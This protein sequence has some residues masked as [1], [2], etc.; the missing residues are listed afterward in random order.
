MAS[1]G[2][3]STS[4][5]CLLPPGQLPLPQH[6]ILHHLRGDLEAKHRQL[7]HQYSAKA[8]Y[9]YE[10]RIDRL[11]RLPRMSL[12]QAEDFCN[13]T[14]PFYIYTATEF[15]PTPLLLTALHNWLY[16]KWFQPYRSEIEWGQFV[17]KVV[18]LR[19]VPLRTPPD[20][21]VD[22]VIRL[23]RKICREV[24]ATCQSVQDLDLSRPHEDMNQSLWG[25][26]FPRSMTEIVKDQQSF[27]LQ[28]L[29][30]AV[31]I[32]IDGEDFGRNAYKYITNVG[33]TH[34]HIVRTGMEYGLSAPISFDSIADK[35]TSPITGKDG[36]V[37]AVKTT[38]E[39]AYQFLMELKRR[40]VAAFG[41]FPQPRESADGFDTGYLA[42]PRGILFE[43][44]KLGWDKESLPMPSSQWVGKDKD[45][46]KDPEWT[47]AGA[48]YAE[49]MRELER[50]EWERV[51][52][53]RE[54]MSTGQVWSGSYYTTKL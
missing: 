42:C 40:E 53:V 31:A 30:R 12:D 29:F 17:S 50:R 45:K 34:V 11:D 8:P 37:K 1:N 52:R 9:L 48:D 13:K 7:I 19:G 32:M 35:T 4:T 46:D 33:H 3:E 24:E 28:P 10:P 25:M 27:F 20:R 22:S 16:D 39:T 44:Q 14:A 15:D 43:A 26:V 49:T 21:L 41:V 47:G 51:D 38:L 5:R 18:R 6:E 54:F 36:R 23:N 2:A